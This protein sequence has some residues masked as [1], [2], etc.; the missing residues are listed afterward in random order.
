MMAYLCIL[1]VFTVT[2]QY[3]D[4]VLGLLSKLLKEGILGNWKVGTRGFIK[5]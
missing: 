1:T 2:S 4:S 5:L 3:W